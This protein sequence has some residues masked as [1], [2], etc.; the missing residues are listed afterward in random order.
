[1]IWP[2]S[3]P[4]SV[5]L[6]AEYGAGP[7]QS[8]QRF[9]EDGRDGWRPASGFS[10]CWPSPLGQLCLCY[11]DALQGCESECQ[12]VFLI[13]RVNGFKGNGCERVCFL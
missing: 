5:Y 13:P 8:S 2:S 7:F 10:L 6:L 9:L 11:C 1:M 12:H 4:E 3:D